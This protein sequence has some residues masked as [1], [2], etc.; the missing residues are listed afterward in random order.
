MSPTNSRFESA[1]SPSAL[2][3]RK[4]A[5]AVALLAAAACGGKKEEP[6]APPAPDVTVTDVVQR[7]IAVG[8]ELTATLRGFEDIEIRA[9]VEGYLKSVDYREGSEVKKGQPLFTIDDQQYRAKLAE[10]KGELARSESALAKA[11][12]DVKRFKPLAEQRA[13]SQAELDNA[14]AAQRSARAVVDAA[15]AAVEKASLDL[16]YCKITS[17]VDGLTG[18]AQRKVGD[19]VGKG[20]PTLLT[21]VSS[22]DPMR[23]SVQIPE[24]LFLKY[25]SKLSVDGKLPDKPSE[26]RPGADLVLADGSVYPERGYIVLVD[27]AVDPQTGTLRADLGFRNPKKVLRP[28]MYGKV[29]YAADRRA[30][31]LLVPQRSVL[32]T[33][34]QYAVVVVNAESKAEAR[35]VKVGPRV[36]SLWIIEEGV[37]PGEKVIVDGAAKV[38]DGVQVKATAFPPEPLPA[39]GATPAP[40]APSAGAPGA[41]GSAP[42]V[43]APTGSSAA[44]V[45]GANAPAK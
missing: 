4:A 17:P 19:L 18:Q 25:A 10:A 16:G 12:L 31:A 23:V 13:I 43:P 36:G 21:T 28:G 15:K 7:D 8:G 33:Q 45:P 29:K 44:P 22:V 14:V 24:A 34:G 20:E 30:G 27:R 9:R 35:K 41:T 1:A 3:L 11:D 6:K 42:P 2:P 39:E 5:L 26:D 37:K 32:E 38:R 40:G